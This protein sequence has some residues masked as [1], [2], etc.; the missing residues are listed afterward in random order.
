MLGDL[1]SK[2]EN[3]NSFK[4]S[5]SSSLLHVKKILG[6]KIWGDLLVTFKF[7]SKTQIPIFFFYMDTFMPQIFIEHLLCARH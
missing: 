1:S 5:S 7:E 2:E 3:L 4:N 6:V